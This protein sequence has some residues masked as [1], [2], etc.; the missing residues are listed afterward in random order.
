MKKIYA[1]L[2]S[3]LVAAMF[4]TSCNV[5]DFGDINKDPNKPSTPFTT[6]L[7]TEA[8]KD[9][10]RF[11]LTTATNGYDP[12]LQEWTGYIS[13]S[14]N[15]QYGPLS[16]TSSYGVSG[17][18]L[19]PLKNLNKIILMNEDPEQKDETN[20]AVLGT[21]ANQIA[22]AK[23]LMAFFY[24]SISDIQGPIVISEAF[25]GA[26]EDNWMP[27]YNTQKEA[28][29]ILD[30]SLKEA[31]AMFDESGTLDGS[32]DVLYGGDIAK[33]KKFNASLRMLMAIKLSDVDP[34]A[35][36]SR[37]AA[38]YANG[39]M[40]SV[41]DGLSWTYDDLNW[42]ML[43]YWVSP[44]YPSAGGTAVPNY[45]IVE[46][47]KALKDPR[48]FEYFDIECY[49]GSRDESIFPRD[50]YDSFYG[51]P[52]GLINNDAVSAWKDCCSS[53]NYKMLGMSATIPIITTARVLLV[54]AE[55]AQRGWIS[56]DAK[57]L[58][59]DGIK[60]SF[61]QWGAKD[62]EKYIASEGVAYNNTIEQIALQRWIAGY[63]ADGV[64]AWSDWR[65]LDVP[66]MPV[67]PGAETQGNLHY[68][69]RLP[70]D[71]TMDKEYN[72]ENYA[73]AIKDLSNGQDTKDARVWWDVKDNWEGVLTEE[74][75]KPSVVIPADWQ[76]EM[77]GTY[78][79]F[80]SIPDM[81]A[82]E[83]P[84][85]VDFFGVSTMETKLWVDL[86]HPTEYKIS[87]FGDGTAEL[88]LSWDEATQTFFIKNQIVGMY[89]GH[90]I[91]VADRDT[92]QGSDGPYRGEWDPEDGCLYLYLMYRQD[93]PRN[94][95]NLLLQ[96]G[97]EVFEP[98]E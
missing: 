7:F 44:D 47:M 2:T 53:I 63:L 39:G 48:M 74:Q 24:M 61:E 71:N 13:E 30:E 17:M 55:A 81:Y 1:I 32:A 91:N 52:F 88:F 97:Y 46:E 34:A 86:N 21:S 50:S 45:F 75:C 83:S 62:V 5:K 23:T 22:A 14:K 84:L 82:N 77:E 70:F 72:P 49:K 87:P 3:V 73:E 38:A 78:Y 27:K 19:Y 18:Y 57:T 67:G 33:W 58:Y 42:N 76:V 4:V 85:G 94:G 92:D 41:A 98:K 25:K 54:E 10:W 60:A 56:A 80:G 31:Y 9:S 43:Y 36:K 35:G 65:R 29:T 11:T 68:P 8:C 89:D 6:Y 15:N 90:P 64:E 79:Y 28:Y 20:V 93:G 51:V 26:S 59:E 66:H 40:T 96:Y 37:F 12:W 69:Y 16:T 95:V